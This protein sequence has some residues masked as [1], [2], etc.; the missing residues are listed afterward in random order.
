[1]QHEGYRE[2]IL[3]G[4]ANTNTE[5]LKNNMVNEI[6][7]TVEPWL[8]GIGLNTAVDKLNVALKLLSIKKLNEKGTLLLKYSVEKE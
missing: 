4:G 7:V 3:V 2:G 5:F 6:W 8:K 1:L